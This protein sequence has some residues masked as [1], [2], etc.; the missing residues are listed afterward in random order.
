MSW[1]DDDNVSLLPSY[2]FLPGGQELINVLI[3]AAAAVRRKSNDISRINDISIPTLFL[4]YT[5]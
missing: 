2:F 3:A 4:L 5:H 1:R